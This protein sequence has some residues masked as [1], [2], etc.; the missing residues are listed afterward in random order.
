MA[1]RPTMMM[2]SSRPHGGAK[3]LVAALA[4]AVFAAAPAFAAAASPAQATFGLTAVGSP[5]SIH[6]RGVP[7]RV[8]HGAVNVRNLSR[9]PITVIL[10]RAEIA[11]ASNGNANFLT[12]GVAGPGLWLSLSA[13]RVRIAPHSSRQVAYTVSIPLGTTGASHYAGIVALNAADLRTPAIRRRSKSTGVTIYRI[14]RQALPITIRIPGPLSRGLSLQSVKLS[15]GSSG[16]SLV[17]GL[18]PGGT[19]LTEAAQVNLRVLRGERTI[20]KSATGLGQLFPGGALSYRIAWPGTP[21]PGT[22]RVVGTIRPVGS[23]VIY[24]DQ[25]VGYTVAKAAQLKHETPPVPVIHAPGSGIPGW[26]W[27]VLAFALALLIALAVVI[28]K[29]SRRLRAA[30]A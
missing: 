16:A 2:I 1:N 17:L 21:T 10:Q 29:L 6:L 11:N 12:T 7:G 30:P 28:W 18:L 27:I 14:S 8:L 3:A 22:Y 15:V 5:G 23:R 25:I 24:I 13:G 9:H 26:V 20:F 19:E 4:L